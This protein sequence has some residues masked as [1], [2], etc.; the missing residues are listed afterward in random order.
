MFNL[1]EPEAISQP[2]QPTHG[3][4]LVQ[5][6]YSAVRDSRSQVQKQ[7]PHMTQDKVHI[8]ETFVAVTIFSSRLQIV[9]VT[10]VASFPW[11]TDSWT[12]EFKVK[13]V[14]KIRQM[15]LNRTDIQLLVT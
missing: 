5:I 6:E 8:R 11:K 10:F 13:M 14:S 15:S 12:V 1:I 2:S 3:S 9:Y 7:W 4:W